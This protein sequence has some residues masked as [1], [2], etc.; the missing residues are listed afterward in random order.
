[1]IFIR[2]W[3]ATGA[4]ALLLVAGAVVGQAPSHAARACT[5]GWTQTAY[6]SAVATDPLGQQAAT[7]ILAVTDNC[8]W[9]EYKYSVWSPTG[10]SLSS[11]SIGYRVWVCGHFEQQVHTFANPAWSGWFFYGNCGNQTD[12][13]SPGSG[14]TTAN[15]SGAAY[16]SNNFGVFYDH[17]G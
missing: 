8:G 9:R 12:N 13:A 11:V 3:V 5:P 10:S 7:D 6:T 17:I 2:R 16:N 14:G 1:M 15:T 4:L